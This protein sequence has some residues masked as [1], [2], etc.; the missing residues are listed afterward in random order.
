MRKAVVFVG[1]GALALL[2]LAIGAAQRS[3]SAA[4]EPEPGP[5]RPTPDDWPEP[6]RNGTNAEALFAARRDRAV[7]L[8]NASPPDE[9]AQ[10]AAVLDLFDL[11][12]I[13]QLA[14]GPELA[15]ASAA[16]RAAFLHALGYYLERLWRSHYFEHTEPTYRLNVHGQVIDAVAKLPGM[17][18]PGSLAKGLGEVARQFIAQQGFSGWVRTLRQLAALD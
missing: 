7:Q 6:W 16:D 4:P 18:A 3:A 2:G 9:A 14:L 1:A 17:T 8:L 15:Q 10:H 5:Y 13:A 11:N 12:G